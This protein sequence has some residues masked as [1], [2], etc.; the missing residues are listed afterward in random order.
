MSS[1][2]YHLVSG[3]LVALTLVPWCVC[4][5][6]T[7]P[8]AMSAIEGIRKSESQRSFS[9]LYLS[10]VIGAVAGSILPLALIENYGFH[11]TLR[12]GSVLNV[13]IAV[14]AFGLSFQR[15]ESSTAEN[16]ALD[17]PAKAGPTREWET[18]LL[19][20]L[21]GLSTMG[22]EV[23]W[24]DFHAIHRAHGLFV[25]VD[26]GSVSACDLY[27]LCVIPQREPH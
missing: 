16:A 19:L 13:V 6:A 17:A 9:Y 24:I 3:T 11:G 26:F 4:M 22:M 23:I 25:C 21:T 8:F 2:T 10:N 5:G 7:Y 1:G 18:L 15:G 12:T 14:S 27:G 20:F